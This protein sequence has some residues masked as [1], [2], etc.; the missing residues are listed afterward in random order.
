[1][2]AVGVPSPANAVPLLLPM[3]KASARSAI[4]PTIDKIPNGLIKV[5]LSFSS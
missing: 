3:A 2:A 4:P 5:M 1:V